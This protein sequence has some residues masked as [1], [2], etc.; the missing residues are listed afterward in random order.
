VLNPVA[1]AKPTSTVL[2]A[3]GP[4]P[5]SAKKYQDARAAAEKSTYRLF[6]DLNSDE[7]RTAYRAT[8]YLS[9]DQREWLLEDGLQGFDIGAVQVWIAPAPHPCITLLGGEEFY[10]APVGSIACGRF[11]FIIARLAHSI[12]FRGRS[13]SIEAGVDVTFTR[14]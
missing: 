2:F 10:P 6:H 14:K 4:C 11:R 12:S 8:L 3:C 9:G 1:S 13:L 5:A 7:A